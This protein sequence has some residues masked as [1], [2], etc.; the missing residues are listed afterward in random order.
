M[1]KY[2]YYLFKIIKNFTFKTGIYFY[3]KLMIIIIKKAIYF[4][5]IVAKNSNF[6]EGIYF[7]FIF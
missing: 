6:K 1:V 4:Y 5:F 3:H 2:F 7:Y